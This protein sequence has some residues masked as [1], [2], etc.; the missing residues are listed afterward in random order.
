MI[1][2]VWDKDS[3]M[4]YLLLNYAGKNLYGNQLTNLY[5]IGTITDFGGL[6]IPDEIQNNAARWDI[7]FDYIS[8][9]TIT[10]GAFSNVNWTNQISNEY[11]SVYGAII[12]IEVYDYVLYSTPGLYKVK[13]GIVDAANRV[14]TQEF[15]VVVSSC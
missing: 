1:Q 2:F 11:S 5:V 6:E 9:K 13:V 7:Y 15:T 8:T 10:A 4:H 12:K 3:A 14:R